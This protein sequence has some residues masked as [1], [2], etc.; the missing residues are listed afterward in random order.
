[1]IVVT[2]GAGFIGSNLVKALNHA[3]HEDILVVDNLKDGKKFRNLV[4]CVILDYID[5]QDFIDSI[6]QNTGFPETISCIF[7]QGAC[8]KTTEWDGRYMMKNN[9]E[10]SKVLFE[11]CQSNNIDFI[12]ASSAA[13]YGLGTRL[14]EDIKYEAPINVYGYSKF[15][16]DQYVRKRLANVSSKVI[17]L[18]YF[19]VYGP[20]EAHKGS[21]A[22]VASH[23]NT[24][25]K[26]TGIVNLFSG[27]DGYADGE[28]RRDFIYVDDIVKINMWCMLDASVSGIFNAGTGQSRSFNDVARCVIDFHGNGQINYIEFPEHLRGSYQSFTEA[29]TNKLLKAG[30]SGG[31]TSLEEGVKS[32]MSILNATTTT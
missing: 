30:Y 12:Y 22:S 13:V 6:A 14:V 18:R 23:L 27:T 16:F 24:Q 7:H 1:M 21:M 26:E 5:K 2:G 8:S 11:Y 17:G 32:Y 20:G 15:L 29:D 9:Y 25:I 31:F 4:D 28:Q 19:N 3:G 10:Y